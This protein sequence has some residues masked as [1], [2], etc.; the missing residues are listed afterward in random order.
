MYRTIEVQCL[1]IYKREKDEFLSKRQRRKRVLKGMALN[2][3]LSINGK[4]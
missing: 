1:N 4:I 3:N 2:V